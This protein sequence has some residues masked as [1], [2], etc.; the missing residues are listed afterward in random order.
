MWIF[1]GPKSKVVLFL[2]KDKEKVEISEICNGGKIRKKKV[3]KGRWKWG[4]RRKRRTSRRKEKS[5]RE[6]K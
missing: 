1:L 2:N 4:R 5:R 6:R 3:T